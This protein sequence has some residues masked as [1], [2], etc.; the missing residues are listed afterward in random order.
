MDSQTKQ[1]SKG[2]THQEKKLRDGVTRRG[3]LGRIG[4]VTAV[5]MAAGSIPLEPLLG[6]KHS[7]AGASIGPS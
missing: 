6:E 4:G 7:V 1:N 2:I 3:F 5:T